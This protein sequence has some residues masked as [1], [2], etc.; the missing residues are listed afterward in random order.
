M[1]PIFLLLAAALALDAP[2]QTNVAIDTNS[3]AAR[4]RAVLRNTNTFAPPPTIPGP[5]LPLSARPLAGPTNFAGRGTNMLVAPGTN[6]Q[7][8]VNNA[9]IVNPVVTPIPLPANAS[10][11]TIGPNPPATST[12]QVPTR[13][14]PP[15]LQMPAF[16]TPNIGPATP[17]PGAIA[18]AEP[19]EIEAG[20][21]DLKGAP[22]EQVF[23]V[24][25]DM[26]GRTVL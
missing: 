25:Q 20:T 3:V 24:Y 23:D 9:T 2:A 12:V 19:A 7:P 11:Q 17:P 22:L 6:T 26:S 8:I 4:A 13:T 18:G 14:G 1:K 15:A 21:I 16:P 10:A 5:S